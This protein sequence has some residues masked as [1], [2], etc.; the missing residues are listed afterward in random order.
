MK[1]IVYIFVLTKKKKKKKGISLKKY[2]KKI[3]AEILIRE[4]RSPYSI[5][6][7]AVELKGYDIKD[8]KFLRG[9]SGHGFT[10]KE[11]KEDYVNKIKGKI[12]IKDPTG[13]RII[14][15]VPNNLY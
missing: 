8:G 2:A 7:K 10:I 12:I 6:K 4:Y 13:E 14:H 11:A 9:V 15:K 1:T 5:G 3:G